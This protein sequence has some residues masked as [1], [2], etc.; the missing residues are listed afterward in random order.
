MI[1]RP[2][3]TTTATPK[4]SDTTGHPQV[5]FNVVADRCIAVTEKTHYR[6]YIINTT[7]A[8]NEAYCDFKLVKITGR[9][10]DECF[11]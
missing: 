9:I 2:Y 10:L 3:Y 1:Y 11:L 5:V 7:W 4:G 6:D 8:I